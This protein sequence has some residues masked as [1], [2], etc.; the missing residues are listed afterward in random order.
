MWLEWGAL[1]VGSRMGSP[2]KDT[3]I[4]LVKLA[5]RG[6]PS[7]MDAE[8]WLMYLHGV[9][10]DTMKSQSMRKHLEHGGMPNYCGDCTETYRA[11]HE[12]AGTCHPIKVT[13]E[14]GAC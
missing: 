7:C 8:G 10:V 13:A 9:R 2:N 12:R 1:V 14:G 4:W 5:D 11:K 3:P 6:A